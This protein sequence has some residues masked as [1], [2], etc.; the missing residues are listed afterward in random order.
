MSDDFTVVIV[1]GVSVSEM[2]GFD[3]LFKDF[4]NR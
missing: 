4:V 2:E 1:T 3:F